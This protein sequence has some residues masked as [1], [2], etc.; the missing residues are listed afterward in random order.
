MITHSWGNVI[1]FDILFAA[2]WDQSDMPGHQ[3]AQDIRNSLFGVEPNPNTG[4]SLASIHTMGSPIALFSL[5]D[6][7]RSKEKTKGEKELTTARGNK[8]NTHD[9]TPRLENL[10][11]SLSEIRQGMPLPWRNF[12]HPGDPV[13]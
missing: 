9:I 10:L 3:S 13:A 4:L 8:V 7:A 11:Q 6:V 2:R 5:I 1:L 12:I